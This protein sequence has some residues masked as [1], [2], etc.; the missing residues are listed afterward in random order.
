MGVRKAEKGC[1]TKLAG[2]CNLSNLAGILKKTLVYFLVSLVGF[3]QAQ[4]N[5][6]KPAGWEIKPVYGQGFIMVHRVTIGHL[7]KG[8]PSNLELNICK[9]TD[10]SKRWQRENNLPL[11]GLTC[12]RLDFANPQQLGQAYTLAPFVDIPL[13]KTEKASRVIFRV[14]WGAT[15]VTKPFDL[16]NNHKN[17]AIGSHLNSFVQFRWY[18]HLRLT[19]R[20][21]FEPGLTFTHASNGKAKNPNLGL[22]VMSVNA[23]LHYKITHT[24][25]NMAPHIDSV[26]E[27]KPLHQLT[28]GAAY[29]FNQRSINGKLLSSIML[30]GSLLHNIRHTHSFSVGGDVLYDQNYQIDLEENLHRTAT[31]MERV[32]IAGRVGY[33]YNIGQVSLPIEIG[34][35]VYQK[36]NPD[37]ILISRLG[38]RY[39]SKKGWMATFGLRTHYAVAYTFEYGLGYCFGLK[40]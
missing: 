27:R 20:L 31:G 29:G 36:I 3:L 25:G 15:Y 38:V 16:V 19:D 9:Q 13:N 7:V 39:F 35:Y 8:Y 22:N 14:C 11:I 28:I 6:T 12:Q 37:A 1:S 5:I 40:K 17:I 30:S 26:V 34:C 23:G 18:W 4:N 32:R 33:A 24:A 2:T 10:G 21:G